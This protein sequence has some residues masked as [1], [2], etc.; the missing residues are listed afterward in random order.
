MDLPEL[1]N[2]GPIAVLAMIMALSWGYMAVW[3]SGLL[4]YLVALVALLPLAK[5][6]QPPT[7][8]H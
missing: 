5:S 4:A 2:I 6:R 7:T 3:A 1:R 8:V